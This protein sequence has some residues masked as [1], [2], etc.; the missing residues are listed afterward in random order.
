VL[1][2]LYRAQVSADPAPAVAEGSADL[3]TT[4]LGSAPS[5]RQ[6]ALMWH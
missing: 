6:P 5:G 1:S 4:P 3:A 2:L